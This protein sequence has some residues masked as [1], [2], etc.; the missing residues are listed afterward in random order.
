MTPIQI[1]DTGVANLRSM[2]AALQREGRTTERTRQAEAVRAAE[3][4]VLPGVGSFARGLANLGPEVGEAVR[5]RVQ[6]G[7][8][9]LT[10][11]LGMQMLAEASDED[12]GRPGLGVLPGTVR[13]LA[14]GRIPHLGWSAVRDRNQ[15][16]WLESG[17]AA[18]A[19]SFALPAAA[20]ADLEAAGW[21]TAVCTTGETSFVAA[22]AR[23]GVLA[24]QFHPELSGAWGGRL[25]RRWLQAGKEF[26]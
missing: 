3:Q 5:R 11:C 7:R 21:R 14:S 26:A 12:P 6:D 22:A 23:G 17:F 15:P 13:R 8:P 16:A 19:H 18:F 1:I 4:V 9:T 24:C 2:E 20:C 25:L 10:V